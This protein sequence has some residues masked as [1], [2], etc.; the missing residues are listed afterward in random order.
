MGPRF[1]EI[2]AELTVLSEL[3]QKPAGTIRIMA[4]DYLTNIFRLAQATE[5]VGQ[6]RDVAVELTTEYGLTDFVC[7]TL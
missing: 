7:A 4:T 1:E 6:F 2:E 5:T 3:R